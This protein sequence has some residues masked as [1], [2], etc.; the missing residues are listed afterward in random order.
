MCLN[1]SNYLSETF[2][3]RYC[4]PTYGFWVL[5]FC[6]MAT[7]LYSIYKYSSMQQYYKWTFCVHVII[8]DLNKA[9]NLYLKIIFVFNC[10][11]PHERV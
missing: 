2:K 9:K 11:P 5:L 6:Q 8:N 1:E 10:K 4:K 3:G 7:P